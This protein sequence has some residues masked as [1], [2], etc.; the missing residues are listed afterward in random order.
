VLGRFVFYVPVAMLVLVPLAFVTPINAKYAFPKFAILLIGSSLLTFLLIGRAIDSPRGADQHSFDFKSKG[1]RIVCAYF[2]VVAIST[3]FGVS[4]LVSFFGSNSSFMGLITRL[5]FLVCWIGLMVGV[6]ASERRLLMLFWAMALAGFL[7]SGYAV[8]QFFGIEPFAAQSTYTF[9]SR[10][11]RVVRV[12]SSLGHSNYL[13]NFL[14][15]TTPLT[16]GLAFTSGGKARLGAL[17][18]A[19]LSIA[20]IVFS[21][22]RGAWLGIVV[23]VGVFAA[24]ELK[25]GSWNKVLTNRRRA[26][27]VSG[28]AVVILVMAGSLIAITPTSRSIAERARA[29]MIEGLSSS[30]RVVLW[31]D[32]IKMIPGFAFVGCGPEGFRKALLG[33]KS[34]ELALLSPKANNESPHNSYLEA[35][36]SHGLAG[37]AL[38]ISI[39]AYAVVCMWRARRRASSKA[40]RIIA[41]GVLASFI[42]VLTHN[43][44]IFDQITNGLY[45]FAFVAVA[46]TLP[47]IASSTA[48]REKAAQR[49]PSPVLP[50][51]AVRW[52]AL[53]V[54][55]AGFVGVVAAAWYCVGLFQAE[56]AYRRLFDPVNP[57][58]Y[59]GM[60]EQGERITNSPLPTGAYDFLYARAL[61]LSVQRI[62]VPASPT[63]PLEPK[64]AE[65]AAIRTEV[66]R[67]GISHAEKSLVHTN[68]PDMNYSLLAS[69]ALAAGDVEKAG[70][71]AAEAVKWDPNNYNTRWLMAEAH[72]ALGENERAISEAKTAL[73]LDPSSEQVAATLSRARGNSASD[74]S[75]ITEILAQAL[76]SRSNPQYSPQQL[77]ENGRRLSSWGR[78][79]KARIPLL[80]A[81]ERANGPCPVCHRE[82]AMV[83]ERLGRIKDAVVEWEAYM[84]EDGAAA[85]A[86]GLSARLESLRKLLHVKP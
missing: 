38:Y 16:L 17:L 57:L 73:R 42:A 50:R 82:L 79:Q 12:C 66:L 65:L 68:T 20:A 54:T 86:E 8:A 60:L 59:R 62:P 71:A 46:F 67:L 83:N 15:Y 21:G 32:S 56:T 10:E 48:P 2:V 70:A 77:I 29:L 64:D 43:F 4:P 69:L 3:L 85:A 47:G 28:A 40:W 19:L 9:D 41:T 24:L 61:Q 6:G 23:G 44:F 5:C 26:M 84:K 58:D 1:V 63:K 33:Y 35:A 74:R 81:I 36:I 31:R 51:S 39:I 49:T 11:G 78:L 72:L 27:V 34:E 30:G 45:F 18:A 55:S 75:A 80:T 52:Q 76:Y 22:T 37:A 25:E 7:V 14:L 53:A 13:G